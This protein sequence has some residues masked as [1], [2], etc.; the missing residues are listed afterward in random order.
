[1]CF[2]AIPFSP[3]IICSLLMQIWMH[4]DQ[5]KTGF[6]GRAEFYNAL[7]L[8]TVAQSKRE[9]TPDMVKAALYG[10]AS[11][12]IPAPQINL[13]A[14]PAPPSNPAAGAAVP[15]LSGVALSPSQ[16]MG[17]RGP[18]VPSNASM[19]PQFFP[20][21]QN[22]MGRP[23]RPT[24]PNTAFRPQQVVGS[25]G[26]PGMGTT[27]AS[28]ALGTNISTDWLGGMTAGSPAGVTTQ[29]ANR[30]IMPLTTSAQ[31]TPNANSG[32]VQPA[33]P[34]PNDP[35]LPSSHVGAKDSKPLADAGN[36][37]ASDSVFGD[38]FSVTSSQPKQDAPLPASSSGGL[39]VTPAI[40]PASTGLQSAVKPSP[41]GS[42]QSAFSQQPVGSQ[43]QKV[44]S[45]VNGNQQVSVQSSTAFNSSNAGLP[46]AAGIPASGQSQV[47]WPRMTQSDV[48]KYTKVFVEVDTDRDGKITGEQARNL[49]LSWRL[50]RGSICFIL[51]LYWKLITFIF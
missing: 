43:N 20:P 3:A 1:M 9:L 4:A 30:G 7:K 11:S 6:L 5:H 2:C 10:P 40:V 46:A 28:Q 38:V 33:A 45:T 34:K 16:N 14:V 42:L 13:S 47:P 29:V 49:F 51:I 12:K 37:F 35:I 32:L 8:V 26:M 50:P 39:P 22:Q 36:G 23:P 41:L 27:A 15:Q 25:Q 19:G 21:Q 18:Q 48:Q 24:T 31:P 44:Q 17:V